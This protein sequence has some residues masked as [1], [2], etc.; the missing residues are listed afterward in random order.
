[1]ALAVIHGP[2][3]LLVPGALALL[4]CACDPSGVAPSP[5]AACVEAGAQCALPE[6]PL[7]VCE[8]APCP[9]DATPPCFACTPQH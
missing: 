7:G 4:L 6:G 1:V 3:A 8:R 9:G 2:R 5:P